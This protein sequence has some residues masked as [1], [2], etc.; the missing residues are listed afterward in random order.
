FQVRLG[1]DTGHVTEDR[2]AAAS[3][4]AT[5]PASFDTASTYVLAS[6]RSDRILIEG[7]VGASNDE[8]DQAIQQIRDNTST[9]FNARL[10]YAL[11]PDVAVFVQTR[12]T[13]LDYDQTDRDAT[14][15][16][17]DAGV[18]FDLGAPFRGEIAVGNFK[19][20]RDNPLYG[21][22]E[23]LNVSG[24]VKWFPTELTTVT[25]LA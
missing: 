19:D 11:S 5:E 8:Y 21:D 2:W 13:D 14:R 25:F 6:Y 16:P 15:S 12:Q 4:G 9:Y 24:N 18:N 22:V 23:G 1:A 17:I 10:S 20:D 7:T 3:F